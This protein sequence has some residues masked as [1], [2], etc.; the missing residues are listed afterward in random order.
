L[1]LATAII[2]VASLS[3]I[4]LPLLNVRRRSGA[5]AGTLMAVLV[6]F[7]ALGAGFM[8]LEVGL[9]HRTIVFVGSP[10]AA[11]SVVI[12]SILSS[13]GLGSLASDRVRC[14]A[15]RSLVF[16]LVG[17]LAV[18]AFYQLGASALFDA[19]FRLPTWAR[20]LTASLAL[21]PAGFFAGWFFPVGLRV[22]SARSEALVPW[23]IAVNGFASVLGSLA[24]LSLG[25]SFGF[26]RVFLVALV[27]YVL[28]VCLVLPV[29]LR[30]GRPVVPAET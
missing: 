20:G 29:A 14:S 2:G 24:T 12:A 10:G 4:L 18:G 19:L 17:L 27:G 5:A 9:I 13:S 25:V 16:A 28:A 6:Y 21:A 15:V 1:Q 3:L 22:A 7:F 26:R 11:V 30:A 23:A 8:L